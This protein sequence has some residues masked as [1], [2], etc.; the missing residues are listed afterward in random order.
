MTGVAHTRRAWRR[1]VIAGPDLD[2]RAEV[3]AAV[4]DAAARQYTLVEHVRPTRPSAPG[5]PRGAGAASLL[6]FRT[7]L[8]H[9]RA[10]RRRRTP[11]AAGEGV[12]VI[13]GSWFDLLLHPAEHGL[14][15]S[16][17]GVGRFLGVLM[18][19]ADLIVIVDGSS[20][21]PRRPGTVSPDWAPWAW[22]QY[23]G[24]LGRQTI[25]ESRLADGGAGAIGRAV[26]DRLRT[27]PGQHAL[28]WA[29]APFSRRKR[30]VRATVGPGGAAALA[31][32]VSTNW[33]GRTALALNQALV[34]RGAAPPTVAPVDDLA[35]L[36]VEIGIDPG[37]LA[38][39]SSPERGR[40]M[41][42]VASD[43]GLRG[44]LKIGSL[45]D[46]GLRREAEAL[47]R[48]QPPEGTFE[49]P[50][51]LWQ[52]AWG[53]QFVLAMAAIEHH[54]IPRVTDEGVAE[55]CVHLH[56]ADGAGGPVVHGDLAPWN[57][58]ATTRC[59]AVVDWEHVRFEADPMSD[60][61]HFMVQHGARLRCDPADT[62][63][64]LTAPGSPGWRYLEAIGVPP[65]QAAEHARR[66]LLRSEAPTGYAQLVVNALQ[67]ETDPTP[68]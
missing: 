49:V 32:P 60:L 41:V 23:A 54:G 8:R 25:E 19:R 18:P 7:V 6:V 40:I 46:V 48:V 12:V 50:V 22:G 42:A 64:R 65:E 30:D 13:E 29:E 61:A 36:C 24:W 31:L 44:V 59:L 45:D 28:R 55:L 21:P 15:T 39:F 63:A 5:A 38:A 14:S 2:R 53:G 4:L 26:L 10:Q 52:G 27:T 35:A 58:L 11:V 68:R 20:S 34:I 16:A 47:E 62:A 33:A 57:L 17:I 43:D 3:A 51:L 1:V 9:W 67:P 66:C 56:R 37:G